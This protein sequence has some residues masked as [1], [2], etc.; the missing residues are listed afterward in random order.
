MFTIFMVILMVWIFG[1]L[2]VLSIKASW[3]IMKILFTVIFLPLIIVG[4][5]V[6]GILSIAFPLLLVLGVITVFAS[7]K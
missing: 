4:L 1:K 5:L 7:K 6:A 3:G 2:L